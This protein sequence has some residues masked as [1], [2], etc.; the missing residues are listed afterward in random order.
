MPKVS[1]RSTAS[2]ARR[3]KSSSR[4][5]RVRN[6]AAYDQALKQRGRVTLWFSM[7]AVQAW[8]YQGRRR[9]KRR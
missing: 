2:K 9:L 6:W 4:I 3:S 7:E 8:G 1:N 5:Y